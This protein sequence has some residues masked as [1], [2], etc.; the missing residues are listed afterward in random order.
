LAVGVTGKRSAKA[1]EMSLI[2]NRTFG[3]LT[4]ASVVYY[5]LAAL[6]MHLLQPELDPLRIPMSPYVLGAYGFVMTTTFFVLCAGLL[7]VGF[8]LI[9]TLPRTRLSRIAFALTLVASA[10]VFIA[11][12]FPTDWPPPPTT[13]AGIL[14]DVA[15][16]LAFPAMTLVPGLFSLNFR[17]DGYWRPVSLVAL[18]LSGGV[19]AAFMFA[20]TQI[21]G[22]WGG[23][24]QRLF[25][26]LLFAWIILVGLHLTRASALQVRQRSTDAHPMDT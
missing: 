19:I 3:L 16:L 15:S 12:I 20:L 6:A 21:L 1:I 11:G 24:A 2:S 4:V 25:F 8:G 14:H 17:S 9:H 26:A 18:A 10:G 22:G 7:G 23:L 5:V 13:A